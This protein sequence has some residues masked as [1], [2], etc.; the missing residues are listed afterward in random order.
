[1]LS[2]QQLLRYSRQYIINGIGAEG[3]KKIMQG[4]VLVIGAGALGSPAMM[5]L[6]G[7]GVGTIGIA[8][9]DRVDLS[10]LQRQIIHTTDSVGEKKTVSAGA[11]I[12]RLNPDVN[13]ITHDFKIDGNNIV[14]VISDY[15]IVIDASD[16]LVTKMMINDACI[17]AGRPL[18]HAGAERFFG[19]I[20]TILPDRG[21]CLRCLLEDNLEEEEEGACAR[22]GILG[23]VTGILGSI[24]ALE[25]IKYLTGTGR[26]LAGRILCFDGLTMD[27]D[28]AEF[29]QNPNCSACGQNVNGDLME[30]YRQMGD[31][32]CG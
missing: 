32:R 10:N 2:A 25:V 13:V 7:A 27:F 29:S 30:V 20:T 18:V 19:Q 28:I 4:R 24:Q 23:P 15:D 11:A 14:S 21:P 8:D 17:M 1:M 9:F 16:R 12:N 6:A 26:L 22:Y 31:N 5:Y 3:Q